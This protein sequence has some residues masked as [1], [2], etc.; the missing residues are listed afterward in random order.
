MIPHGKDNKTR[1][2]LHKMLPWGN[3]LDEMG[4]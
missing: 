2:H 1:D 3:V 4:V